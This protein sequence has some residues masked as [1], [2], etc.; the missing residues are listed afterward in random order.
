[1]SATTTTSGGTKPPITPSFYTGGG[2]GSSEAEYG[3][4]MMSGMALVAE[5]MSLEALAIIRRQ[6]ATSQDVSCGSSSSLD[7]QRGERNQQVRLPESF[8]LE[9][10]VP[11]TSMV[12]SSRVEASTSRSAQGGARPVETTGVVQEAASIICQ[13]SLFSATIMSHPDFSLAAVF[14]R[15]ATMCELGQSTVAPTLK[16]ELYAEETVGGQEDTM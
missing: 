2:F 9:E 1:M 15:A 12:Y 14:K 13:A 5:V 8:E 16:T 7:P 11:T 3:D 4:F 6:A 10:M